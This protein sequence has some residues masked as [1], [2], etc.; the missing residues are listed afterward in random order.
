M[1]A[2]G[3]GPFHYSELFSDSILAVASDIPAAD[4]LK[5][6][7]WAWDDLGCG[8]RSQFRKR[9]G[10]PYGLVCK[11]GVWYL[12]ADQ[13]GEPRLFR[14]SRVAWA[15]ADEAPVR[16]RDGVEL[17]EL[18]QSLRRQVEDRPAP[19]PTSRCCRR[20]RCVPTW[21]R[22]RRKSSRA[23]RIRVCTSGKLHG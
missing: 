16:R 21:P 4:T 11:A 6:S 7:Y 10:D 15:A 17:A 12:V 14:V 8:C 18:W 1:C 9:R 19:V 2:F 5:N 13:R 20:P 23:T 3:N 22:S